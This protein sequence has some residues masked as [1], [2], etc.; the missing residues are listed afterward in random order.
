MSSVEVVP[1]VLP[2][3]CKPMPLLT[4]A[5][6]ARSLW[7]KK[8]QRMAEQEKHMK[9]VHEQKRAAAQAELN[10]RVSLARSASMGRV[11]AARQGVLETNI[12]ARRAEAEREKF[13]LSEKTR[14]QAE[15]RADHAVLHAAK[16]SPASD[17][18]HAS[19]FKNHSPTSGLK[20]S[21]AL[22]TRPNSATRSGPELIKMTLPEGCRPASA[23]MLPNSA[24]ARLACALQNRRKVE[25]EK[26]TKA[27]HDRQRIARQAELQRRVSL[28]RSTSVGRV[29]AARQTVFEENRKARLAESEW[30]RFALAEKARRLQELKEEH[31]F[32]VASKY[33]SAQDLASLQA[34]PFD[35]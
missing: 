32:V 16:Y 24:H 3:G 13:A 25:Q 17:A 12:Q 23:T 10:R 20:K 5:A 28:A 6:L 30:E 1:L 26:M 14:R 2:H 7:M 19:Q 22:L 15:L 35:V 27:A 18:W 4:R 9:A 34:E 29:E 21:A 8:N 33:A 11:D 31:R